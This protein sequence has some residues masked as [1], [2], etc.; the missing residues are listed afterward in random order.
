[1]RRGGDVDRPPAG[2][3]ER[4]G[5]AAERQRTQAAQRQGEDVRKAERRLV[6]AQRAYQAL[7]DKTKQRAKR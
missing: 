4:R 3:D 6:E 5:D 2:A 1:M 7:L